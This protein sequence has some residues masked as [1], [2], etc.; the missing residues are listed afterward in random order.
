M[1]VEDFEGSL[2]TRHGGASPRP[3]NELGPAASN[4][5]GEPQNGF[6]KSF[7]TPA[8]V[9]WPHINRSE[10]GYLRQRHAILWLYVS[11]RIT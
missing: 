4:P 9:N 1:S 5:Q 7:H 3:R 8:E 6:S 11:A 10:V 2:A